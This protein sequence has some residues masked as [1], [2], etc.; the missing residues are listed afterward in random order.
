MAIQFTVNF[1]I[2]KFFVF[3]IREWEQQLSDLQVLL[4][5]CVFIQE[6]WYSLEPLLTSSDV[7]SV[8]PDEARKFSA[9][10]KVLLGLISL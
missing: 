9:I 3:V 2:L 4:E 6:R 8:A 5:Q 10:D 1:C 7:L